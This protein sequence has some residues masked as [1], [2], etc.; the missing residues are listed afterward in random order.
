MKPRA[1]AT[2]IVLVAVALVIQVPALVVAQAPPSLTTDQAL[3][4]LRDKQVALQGSGY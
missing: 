3:Y 4:T 2:I 1:A